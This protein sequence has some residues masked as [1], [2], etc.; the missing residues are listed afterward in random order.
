MIYFCCSKLRRSKL[1]DHPTLNGIDFLEVLDDP[2]LPD[3]QRQRTLF[4]HFVNPLR[5]PLSGVN[6]RLEGGERIR[7]VKVV[8]VSPTEQD[9]VLAVKVD[10]PGDFSFYSLRLVKD[11]NDR[12]SGE[13]PDGFDPI[14]SAVE[15]SFKVACDSEFDCQP[16]RVCPPQPYDQPEIDYLAKDYA[17]F[18]RLMLDRM[19]VLMPQWKERNP[20]D[21]GMVLVELLAYVGDYLSYQQDAVA[22]EAYLGT[23]RRRVSV[24]RHA[25]LVDYFMHDGCNAR[26]WVHVRV[27]AE[28]VQLKQRVTVGGQEVAT[29]LFTRV[30]EQAPRIEPASLT[31]QQ[32]RA[33]GVEVFELLQEVTLYQAHN[34]MPFY[35]WDDQRCCLPQGAT[36]AALKGHYSNLVKGNVLI[37]QEMVGPQT[38]E[39]EDADPA[40]RHAVRLT[41]VRQGIDLLNNQPITEIVWDSLDALP[42]PVCISSRTD[43]GRY[44]EDVSLALGNIVL[45]DHGATTQEEKFAQVPETAPARMR[46]PEGDRCQ[47]P[48]SI[49]VPLR[50]HPYLKERPLTQTARVKKTKIVSGRKEELIIPFDDEAAAA[51]AFQWKMRDVLPHITITEAGGKQ[52]NPQRDLLASDE[53]KPEF[54]V[55]V[56]EDM[57]AAI[58][59]GDDRYGAQ[60]KEKTQF[61]ACYRVGNGIQGNVGADTLKHIVSNDP[62]IE[63]VTNPL[64]ASGGLEPE[65]MEDVRQR[66]PVAF[67]TQERAVTPEDYA[68]VAEQYPN[69]QHSEVQRA[70]ATFHWTGS[71]YTVFLTVDRVAG[72]EVDAEFE[73]KLRQ[74][75]ERYRLAGHDVEIAGPK[76]VPLKIEMQVSVQP[77]FF[78][79][80][81]KTALLQIFSNQTLPDG[82]RGVFHPDNFTFGQ[83][84]YLSPLYTAAQSVAGIASVEITKFQRQGLESRQALDDGKLVLNRLEIARLDNDPNFPDRGVFDPKMKGGK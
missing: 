26:V 17:S 48:A 68:R 40:H 81:V 7:N 25:R 31:Y 12:R 61:S 77:D 75:L 76:Y 59:F 23:A 15:F 63:Q 64:P 24:R 36:R 84:V 83:T 30:P 21:V 44:I 52:W 22:T 69:P 71:W 13:P 50:F 46:E 37:F 66:A 9:N 73:E 45:A 4:V 67:R 35:T 10:K 56:E 1:K 38:G 78:R 82:R 42:F 49:P 32:A 43:Q 3:E 34:E 79:S 53:F 20:A 62:A 65:S 60:P 55:E 14:L 19:A 39:P 54:V 33:A 72:R 16:A 41:E 6:L 51:D 29:Q 70:M 27:N 11:A 47:E 57:R 2:T 28:S 58:R 5:A 8:A 80:N 18:R 74:H